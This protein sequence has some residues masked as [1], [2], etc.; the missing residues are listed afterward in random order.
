MLPTNVDTG[1][2]E[3]RFIVGVVDGP[4]GDLDP[5]GIPA[6]GTVTFTASVPYLPNPFASPAAVTLVHAGSGGRLDLLIDL[7]GALP[8]GWGAEIEM[9]WL[10]R[11]DPPVMEIVDYSPGTA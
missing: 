3:G 7:P 11:L 8:D 4:D 6:A 5:D 9:T 1:R 10:K 2:V